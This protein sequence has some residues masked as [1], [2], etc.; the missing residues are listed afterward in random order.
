MNP[1]GV[2][3]FCLSWQPT[4]PSTASVDEMG[5]EANRLPRSLSRAD[6]VCS[7][8]E[9]T[10]KLH[11]G[12]SDL[13]EQFVAEFQRMVATEGYATRVQGLDPTQKL[14]VDVMAE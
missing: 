3:Y 4:A 11:K 5:W 9:I 7:A 10:R 14:V 1:D 13:K 12:V 2:D 6:F 8:S